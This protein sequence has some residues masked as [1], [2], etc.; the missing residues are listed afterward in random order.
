MKW[1]GTRAL[2]ISI[3]VTSAHQVDDVRVG[4]RHMVERAAAARDAGL[5]ALYVGDHHTTPAPYYQNTAILGRMLAEWG[6]RPAGA[7]YLLPLWHPVLAA[8]QIATLACICEGPFIMQCGIGRGA[9]DFARMGVD[10]RHRPSRFEQ[11]LDVMRRLWAGEHVD[12]DGRWKLQDAYISPLPPE[13]IEVHIG[14]AADAAIERAARLGDG[15]LGDPGMTFDQAEVRLAKYREA[16]AR[17]GV[18]PKAIPIRRD[19]FV[20]AD[21]AEAERVMA[22]Y[23]EG[24]YRGFDADALVWGDADHVSQR[25]DALGA[26]GFTEIVIRNVSA[27]QTECLATIERLGEVREKLER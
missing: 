1:M 16:C 19:V 11:A 5:D 18:K 23:I 22:P 26:M 3:S 6:D 15:W 12:L 24:G 9:R 4:A 20:G 17:Y 2:K 7:L 10:I 21:M 14:A 27:N 8:E 25:F 13:P